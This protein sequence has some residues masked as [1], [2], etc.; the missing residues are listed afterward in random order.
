MQEIPAGENE[1]PLRFKELALDQPILRKCSKANEVTDE[2][3]SRS[4]FTEIFGSML[5][6]AGYFCATSIHAIRRQ[7]DK[8]VDE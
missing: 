6:N 5:R 2:S 4:A 1:L 7:L 8:K 3:M